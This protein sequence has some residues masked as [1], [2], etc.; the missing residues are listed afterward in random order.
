MNEEQ[1]REHVALLKRKV[2]DKHAEM[3]V[4]RDTVPAKVRA[5]AP[6]PAECAPHLDLRLSNV[7]I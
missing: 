6:R 2:E 4:L 3:L 7:R 5:N 1:L